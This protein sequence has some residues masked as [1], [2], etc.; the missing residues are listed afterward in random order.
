MSII[1]AGS[2]LVQGPRTGQAYKNFNNA[3]TYQVAKSKKKKIVSQ[4]RKMFM[5]GYK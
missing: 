3:Y 4:K 2:W 1:D 5:Q